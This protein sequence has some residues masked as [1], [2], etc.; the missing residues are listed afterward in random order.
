M[1]TLY[2]VRHAKSSWKF[3]ELADFDR[4]LNRRGQRDAPEMGRR[5]RQ[6][7]AC[8]QLILCSPAVRTQHTAR[9]LAKAMEYPSDVRYVDEFYEASPEVLLATVQTVRD[10][11]ND[12][13][14]VGHNPGLTELVNRLTAH[15]IEN[16]ATAGVVA[17]IFSVDRWS[18]VHFGIGQFGGY[19]YPKLIPSA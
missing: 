19:D 9:A 7:E 11:V 13:M 18:E 6:R 1:K 5:L 15:S 8:P 16:V 3:P 4:P 10:A 17:V 2:L 12:L 14:L